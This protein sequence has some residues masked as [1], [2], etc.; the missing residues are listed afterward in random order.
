MLLE[1]DHHSSVPIYRQVIRQIRQQ[2]MTDGLK[3]ADQLETVRNLTVRLKVNPM[4]GLTPNYLH[5]TGYK[6]R[7]DRT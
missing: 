5:S 1:I 4:T 3:E 6:N 2:I 7:G